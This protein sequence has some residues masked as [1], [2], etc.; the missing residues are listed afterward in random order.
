MTPTLKEKL[1]L[2][3]AF[4]IGILLLTACSSRSSTPVKPLILTL[5]YSV[6]AL[7]NASTVAHDLR[8]GSVDL[9][10]F[11]PPN[12]CNMTVDFRGANKPSFG[13][14]GAPGQAG[15][16]LSIAV[17]NPTTIPEAQP[18]AC[19]DVETLAVY[20]GTG[21][22]LVFGTPTNQGYAEI[23]IGGQ[24]LSTQNNGFYSGTLLSR[25]SSDSY[26][27]GEFEFMARI[28]DGETVMVSG[29]FAGY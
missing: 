13:Q 22:P 2:V 9:S 19:V 21:S 7:P 18:A 6:Q 26:V 17:Q 16:T 20:L 15:G 4:C 24:L 14:N 10:D 5:N 29:S 8:T 12:P 25:D 23:T 1:I 28:F 11:M 3:V 27:T